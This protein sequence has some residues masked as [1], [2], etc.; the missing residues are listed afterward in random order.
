MNRLRNNSKSLSL[1]AVGFTLGFLVTEL[2]QYR[3]G[4]DPIIQSPRETLLPYLSSSEIAKLP[5]PPDALPGARDIPSPHG[6]L[7]VYEWGPEN[8]R[9]VLMIHGISTPSIALGA[10]ST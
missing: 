9:R 1:L 5:Y 3:R 10:A 7:R 2:Y 6:S 8:G 4:H